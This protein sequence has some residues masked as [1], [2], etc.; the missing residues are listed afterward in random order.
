[1]NMP[2][3]LPDDDGLRDHEPGHCFYCKQKIGQPHNAECVCVTK[4]IKARYV[5]EVELE[6]PHHWTPHDFEFNRNDGSWCADNA[7]PE[8]EQYVGGGDGDCLCNHFKA[9]FLGVLDDTP[10]SK[11]KEKKEPDNG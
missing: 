5:F 11:S 2:L 7:I 3:V 9:E 6:I 10:R 8:L 4:T 1:M